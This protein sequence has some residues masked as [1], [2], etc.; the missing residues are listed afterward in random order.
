MLPW[1]ILQDY[2]YIRV[3]N[4]DANFVLFELGNGFSKE[5]PNRSYGF[6]TLSRSARCRNVYSKLYESR[7][8][9]GFVFLTN[10]LE[11]LAYLQASRHLLSRRVIAGKTVLFSRPWLS[12]GIIQSCIQSHA[13]HLPISPM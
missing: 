5:T 6:Q 8:V 9:K 11:A 3:K 4:E 7:T 10:F 13:T 2:Q 12:R 1:P